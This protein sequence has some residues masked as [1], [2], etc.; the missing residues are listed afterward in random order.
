M[1][2]IVSIAMITCVVHDVAMRMV[3][4]F[5]PDIAAGLGISIE[6]LGD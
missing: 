1:R 2:R 4:P 5:L 3:Y 6:Q